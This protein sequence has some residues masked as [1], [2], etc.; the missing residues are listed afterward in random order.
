MSVNLTKYVINPFTSKAD[1]NWKQF[2]H[3]VYIAQKLMDDV[4][5]LEEEKINAILKKIESD[6]EPEEIKAIERNLWIKIKTKLLDGRRTGLSGIGLADTLAMLNISYFGGI[7]M[8]ES[9]YKTL[10]I[11]AYKSSIDMAKDRGAFPIWKFN[12]EE[13][14]PFLLRIHKELQEEIR[15]SHDVYGRRNIALLTI[16]P[17]G[18]I[19]LLAGISSG[20]EPV[21]Q[22]TYKR[23]RKVNPDHP[24]ISFVDKNGDCWEE[25]IVYHPKYEE[26]RKLKF[27]Y[28]VD[29]EDNPY[30]GSTAYE[31][32]PIDRVKMQAT[33]QKWVDHSISSTINL[34]KETT[35]EQVSDIYI[36]AWKLDCKGITIYRDGCRDGVLVSIDDKKETKF[37]SHDAP[38]RPKVL[39]GDL[40]T[41]TLN[42]KDYIV[43][44]G[45]YDGK[46]YEVFACKN[47]WNIKGN[48]VCTIIKQ[49]RGVYNVDIKDVIYIKDITSDMTQIEENTTRLISTSLRHGA[50]IKF[51]VEQLLKT[52]G[53]GFQDFSKVIAR[54]LK[55]YI[56]DN[57]VVTG[58]T[59]ENCGSDKLIYKDGCMECE[60]C[61]SQKCG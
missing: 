60:S 3:D 26:W 45:L 56:K 1:F 53:N 48:Y 41:P 6:P 49:N 4:V 36:Q 18:T 37:H 10:A 28:L 59:C 25:Y 7:D 9:I 12:N 13:F 39:I 5:D 16:P 61:G 58:A 52:R 19:S 29:E 14:N 42:N 32:N 35:E 44:V 23:R 57:E 40:Y 50:D 46:P 27:E 8:A 31:L 11:T 30:K 21:Y 2:E 24:N 15:Y 47:T 17:S 51:L 54:K 33:I 38:K 43:V 34:P 55:K 22:L 20:I